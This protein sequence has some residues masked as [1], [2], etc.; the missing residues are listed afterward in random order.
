MN[1][2]LYLPTILRLHLPALCIVLQFK[3]ACIACLDLKFVFN[4]T[5]VV[6]AGSMNEEEEKKKSSFLH[7]L[8]VK[9]FKTVDPKII[10]Q[11]FSIGFE[12][13]S[14]SRTS[15]KMSNQAIQSFEQA[16]FT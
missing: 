15:I 8:S 4:R 2:L 7:F 5:Q 12:P 3:V 13:C 1:L 14:S 6:D 11:L 16:H 10:Q 9:L